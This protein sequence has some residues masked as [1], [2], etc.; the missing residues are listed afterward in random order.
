MGDVIL[1]HA[2][3]V[4]VH[5]L[6]DFSFYD[7]LKIFWNDEYTRPASILHL[8]SEVLVEK[9][10]LVELLGDFGTDANGQTQHQ[11]QTKKNTPEQKKLTRICFSTKANS[12]KKSPDSS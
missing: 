9:L 2:F 4:L 12:P 7:R 8:W 3:H 10:V 1:A 5:A 11:P 6:L